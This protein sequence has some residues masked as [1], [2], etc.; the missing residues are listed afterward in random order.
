[1]TEALGC[2]WRSDA[3]EAFYTTSQNSSSADEYIHSL[4]EKK[5]VI[6]HGVGGGT[7]LTA[8]DKFTFKC[9]ML[10]NAAPSV[11][12]KIMGDSFDIVAASVDQVKAKIRK[13]SP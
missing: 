2:N 10:F 12:T 4:E 9:F 3:L 13:I 1:M 11:K 5:S 6:D 8:I 7:S